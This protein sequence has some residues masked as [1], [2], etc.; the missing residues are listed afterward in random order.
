MLKGNHEGFA[1][2]RRTFLKT[3]SI[4]GMAAAL[5]ATK[6]LGQT[7]EKALRLRR[8]GARRKLLFMNE[9]PQEYGKLIE[10]LKSIREVDLL[11]VA[12]ASFKTAGEIVNSIKS[13]DPDIIVMSLPSL[14]MSSGPMADALEFLNIPVIFL[15]RNLDLIMVEADLAGALRMKGVN[16][17]LANSQARTTELVKIVATPGILEGKQALIFG[18]PYDSTS[19]PAHNLNETYIYNLTG[20][21]LQFRPLEELKAQFDK[22][23]DASAQKE[24]D[25]WKKGAVKVLEATDKSILDA[26]RLYI[27]LRSIIDKE[28]LAGISI[29]CLNFSFNR[30]RTLPT[31][32]LAFTRLRDEGVAAPCEADVCGML[33]SIVMQE[34]SRKPSYFYNISGVNSENSN[35]VLRHCVAPLKL[36]GGDKPE[37]KYNIRD[38]HGMGGASPE[39][40]FPI[41]IEVTMGGFTKDLKEFILWPGRTQPQIMDT[42][43]PSFPNATGEALKMRMF[44]SNRAEVKIRDAER[45]VQNIADIHHT[46]VAG[47]Y[48]NAL[49]DEML[50]L[51]V[52]VIGPFNPTVPELASTVAPGAKAKQQS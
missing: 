12:P 4:A 2:N 27:L 1:V 24:M 31:P 41:G 51:N 11:P 6:L 44:C 36:L 14:G 40:T 52:G 23:S 32:C 49:R 18:R 21:K 37:L 46:M 39:V 10:S 48:S 35:I 8:S 25:R 16:A 28:G 9:A 34:I 42:H 38:Y 30:N 17:L 20:L 33:S 19:V 29:D 43:R 7:S 26:C 47:S 15:P 22:V 3:T 13:Q 45:F 5:P 50:K